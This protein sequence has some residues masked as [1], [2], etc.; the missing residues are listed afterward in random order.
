MNE[1]KRKPIFLLGGIVASPA[2]GPTI[3]LSGSG[4]RTFQASVS[5]SGAVTATVIFEVSNDPI[6]HGWA[7]VGTITLTGTNSDT[8]GFSMSAPWANVRARVTGI[9]GSGAKINVTMAGEL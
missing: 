5:G 8:A 1:K 4:A 6:A 3:E 9:S 2:T 7:L